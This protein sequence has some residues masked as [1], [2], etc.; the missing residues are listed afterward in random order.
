[1]FAPFLTGRNLERLAG[2]YPVWTTQPADAASV[3][4]ALARAWHESVVRRGPAL[5]VV[6][7][8]DWDAPLGDGWPGVA[9]PD[10]LLLGTRPSEAA[11]DEL[12]ALVEAATSPALVVGAGL[13]S[14]DGWEAGVA[15]AE[16]LS[17]PVWQDAFSSR[18]GFP[19]GHHLFAGHL[20]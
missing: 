5:V 15:L 19:H 2:E 17:C 13:D 7:M 10:R 11:V 3:P 20:P 8:G 9:A 18:A 1:S 12:A 16:R 6:P 4:G 14:E